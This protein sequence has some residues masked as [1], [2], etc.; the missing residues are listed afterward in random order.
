M[1]GHGFNSQIPRA[2]IDEINGAVV[3]EQWSAIWD[4]L[5]R[6]IVLETKL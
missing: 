1:N 4:F 5:I 2:H 6:K 3:E